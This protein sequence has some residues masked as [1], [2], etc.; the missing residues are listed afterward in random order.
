MGS[1]SSPSTAQPAL[2]E[3]LAELGSATDPLDRQA[4]LARVQRGLFAGA[5]EPVRIGRFVVLERLGTGTSGVVYAAYDPQL[6][7]KIALKVLR[8]DT[9]LPDEAHA[10]LQR[11]AQALARLSHPHVVAVHDVG[12]VDGRVFIAME[13]LRG[14][15]LRQWARAEP[16][17]PAQ[18]LAAYRQAGEGLAAAHAVGLVHRDFKPDNVLLDREGRVR[19]VDFGLA[20]DHGDAGASMIEAVVTGEVARLEVDAHLTRTGT[21]MGTPAYMAPEQHA[22]R[23]ADARTDQYSFCVSLYEALYGERPFAGDTL[24]TLAMAAQRGEVLP[25]APGRAVPAWVR[26]ALL[27][28]L[29]PDPAR[30][31]P[32]MATLL[33]ALGRD[34]SARWRRGGL[35]ALGLSTVVGLT[36]LAADRGSP[37][38]A[39]S[40]FE[41]RLEG[42]WDAPRQEAL[43]RGLAR[44]ED[45][46][47]ADV[48]ARVEPGLTE[49]AH[50]WVAARRDACE[51]TEVHQEQSDDLLDRR[52]LCLDRAL[53]PLSAAVDRLAEPDTETL[54]RAAELVPDRTLVDECSAQGVLDDGEPPPAD[55]R[56]RERIA[57]LESRIATVDSLSLAGRYLEGLEQAEQV[58]ADA[59]ALGHAPTQARALYSLGIA[60][61]HARR[62]QEA[63]E[64]LMQ[65]IN[66]ADRG[67]AD[68]TRARATYRL[69][70]RLAD[71]SQFDDARR[72]AMATEALYDR[73]AEPPV[74]SAA[75]IALLWGHVE[76]CQG[77]YDAARA[78][79][80]RAIELTEGSDDPSMAAMHTEAL[81]HRGSLA[82]ETERPAEAEVDLRQALEERAGQVG[83]DHPE[84]AVVLSNLGATQMLLGRPA[85]A[86]Q[87]FRRSLEI[88]RRRLGPEHESLAPPLVNLG[89][90]IMKQGRYAEAIA[91]QQQ[92]LALMER[93]LGPTHA[94]LAKPLHNLAL[95]YLRLEQPD[96]ALKTVQ[97]ARQIRH[98]ALGPF[99]A[100]TIA[101]EYQLAYV[102]MKAGHLEQ[103]GATYERYIA[104]MRE[105]R[106]QDSHALTAGLLGLADVNLNRGRPHEAERLVQQAR[107]AITDGPDRAD[108]RIAADFILARALDAQARSPARARALAE[109]ALVEA[110][111]TPHA[112]AKRDTIA[113]WLAEHPQIDA[114]RTR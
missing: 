21:V 15:T 75:K 50:A 5:E 8:A 87:M 46:G 27:R 76:W 6:D 23:P 112:Q 25:P 83:P 82:N 104:R 96:E 35:V 108:E 45:P 95:A 81:S 114:P 73:L 92:A 13:L 47:S 24:P 58:V 48:W 86:E 43:E 19:V 88:R 102:Q 63:I 106:P 101:S 66:W 69:V 30:R 33:T 17:R 72:L 18:I 64:A 77:H 113:T 97:R 89:A 38:A 85:Q 100:K 57:A 67:R 111:T 37:P 110:E 61:S 65:A 49:Y 84:L 16:R 70:K 9:D 62:P 29:R 4:V 91:L 68:R 99:H 54:M 26:R 51:A 109:R 93:S 2:H 60:R 1:A 3:Q 36:W 44:G 98:D 20:R 32:D 11:E 105:H 103:A 71:T 78:R 52:V 53:L 80:T 56:L 107:P 12:D 14:G 79:L 28:G 22:G 74:G 94:E 42:I 31:Y 7:R 39:C 59:E 55:P 10:R 41:H 34:P 40:G 90:I